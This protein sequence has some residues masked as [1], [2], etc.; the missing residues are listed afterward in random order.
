MLQLTPSRVRRW[1]FGYQYKVG[2]DR[3]SKRQRPVVRRGTAEP[4]IA[5]FLDLIDLL[6][7]KS[8]LREGISLQ[9]VRHAFD[10]A[11]VVLGEDHPFAR[12][13]FFTSGGEIYL[14][15]PEHKDTPNLLHLLSGGQ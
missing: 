9:K 5:S 13:R 8:F 12:G 7:A 15:M 10:E 6:D 3:H 14:E 4:R 2:A 11:V 1:L